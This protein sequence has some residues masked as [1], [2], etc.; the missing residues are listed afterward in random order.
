MF[1]MFYYHLYFFIFFFF[2]S[3]RRHT[4]SLC[5]WSSDVCSS[6]LLAAPRLEDRH[7]V[8]RR[9]AQGDAGGRV[10]GPA[11]QV[12][13]AALA[14]APLLHEPL[15][16]LLPARAEHVL[17]L[18]RERKLVRRGGQVGEV[19][20]LGLVIED[21]PLHRPLEEV[22]RMAAEE[23]VERVLAGHVHGESGGAAPGAA[24]H[25][26]EARHRSGEG[27]AQGGVELADVDAELE[28][29]GGHYGE[30]LA[31]GQVALDLPALNRRIAG[32][33]GDDPRREVWAP[34]IFQAQT[35]VSLYQ[36]DAAA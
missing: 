18:R 4:R 19:D 15:G 35:R 31:L 5:D 22:V 30:Q 9:R 20:L 2:S 26:A 33:I 14:Q 25:L 12:A 10:A 21:G 24:P 17:V 3:R 8:R 32:P 11:R 7:R 1:C 16:M 23:L 27:H 13:S 36:L 28:G 34:R 6:D 29:V